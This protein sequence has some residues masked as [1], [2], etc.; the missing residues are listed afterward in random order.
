MGGS[1]QRAIKKEAD[2]SRGTTAKAPPIT[3]PPASKASPAGRVLWPR[4]QDRA[5]NAPAASRDSCEVVGGVTCKAAPPL[6]R[7]LT[8]LDP[9]SFQDH[10]EGAARPN[11][12]PGAPATNGSPSSKLM[13]DKLW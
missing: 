4:P 13:Y 8:K 1:R 3:R 11:Q 2:T 6:E 9:A 12:R 5:S 10:T 7:L